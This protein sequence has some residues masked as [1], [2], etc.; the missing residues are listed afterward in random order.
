GASSWNMGD[1]RGYNRRNACEQYQIRRHGA[2]SFKHQINR[3]SPAQPN[4]GLDIVNGLLVFGA[5]FLVAELDGD[6]EQLSGELERYMVVL[7][8]WRASIFAD[9]EGFIRR[10]A[11]RDGPLE[12]SLGRLLAVHH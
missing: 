5:E 9:V 3:G 12:P 2:C 10:D 11:E 8:D 4:P 7:A 1:R 6:T